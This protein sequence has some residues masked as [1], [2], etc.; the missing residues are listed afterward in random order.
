MAD[1]SHYCELL[2]EA[3]IDSRLFWFDLGVTYLSILRQYEKAVGA[4]K[5][6]GNLNLQRCDNWLYK[7]YYLWYARALHALGNHERED[8]IFKIAS[9]CFSDDE[10]QREILYDQAICF[11]S[12]DA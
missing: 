9:E 2:E 4:F 1:I 10:C 7:D 11:V 3:S 5:W 12:Q 6:N 8:E